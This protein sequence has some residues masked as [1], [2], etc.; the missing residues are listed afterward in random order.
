MQNAKE[1]SGIEMSSYEV[2]KNYHERTKHRF[3]AYA[4]GPETLDWDAQPAPFRY[5]KGTTRIALPDIALTQDHA[6]LRALDLPF[7]QICDP[8]AV[9]ACNLL[10]IGALLQL[11]FGITAWKTYGPDRWAVRANPSSG[12]LHPIEVYVVVRGIQEVP[13]GVYH[14]CVESHALEYRAEIEEPLNHQPCLQVGL[15]AV[16]WREA[17]KYGE[18]AF[19]YCQLDTGHAIAALG[20]A[21]AVLGW[22]V[23]EDKQYTSH[24][25]NQLLGLDRSQDFPFRRVQDTELEEGEALLSIQFAAPNA[26][27]AITK[28]KQ[29]RRWYGVASGIDAYPMYRWPIIGEVAQATRYQAAGLLPVARLRSP[30]VMQKSMQ[31]STAGMPM[32]SAAQVILGRRSAQR[33]D[34]HYVM[35][36][37]SFLQM[38]VALIPQDHV[39][40][41]AFANYPHIN[42]V[43]LVHR[44]EGMVPGLYLL[45]RTPRLSQQL[46]QS[47]KSQ[48]LRQAVA[49]VPEQLNFTLLTPVASAELHQISRSLHCHQ[50][51][52][53]NACFAVGMLAEFDATLSHDASSYRDMHREAGL[54]GQ[55]LYLQAEL[56]GMR[57]TGIGCFF[58]ESVH[59]LLG[60]TDDTFQTIYH[61]TVGLPIDDPRLS[62]VFTFQSTPT[63][64]RPS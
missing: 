51:I 19:R 24:A 13:D 42:L 62:T 7:Q 26:K 6:L 30:K 10:S 31:Q 48:F 63:E 2:V 5:F 40:W 34:A 12:N 33:F 54:I 43:F 39:P 22:S 38:L 41:S 15:S 21:A 28:L 58:D 53:A 17:W 57:G 29:S 37:Q 55:V 25:I 46:D 60:L 4:A 50:D 64:T 35:P 59:Q 56:H 32:I 44:V 23:H 20:Y 8:R 27:A 1:N 9:F 52:A 11:S 61:F 3:E 49:G 18:R 36:Q 47:L 45:T 14:Y 16:M